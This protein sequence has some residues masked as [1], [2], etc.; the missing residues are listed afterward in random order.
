MS[1]SGSMSQP[2]TDMIVHKATRECP[3][4]EPHR[5]DLCGLVKARQQRQGHPPPTPP[6]RDQS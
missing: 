5:R 2:G 6:E 4:T 1:Q 3:M